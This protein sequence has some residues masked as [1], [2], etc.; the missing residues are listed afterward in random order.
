MRF[1]KP[2]LLA[3]ATLVVALCAWTGYWFYARGLALEVAAAWIAARQQEGWGIAHEPVQAGG[4]PFTV[5]LTFGAPSIAAPDNAWQW[6]GRELALEAQPWN[7]RRYRLESRGAQ[8]LDI[9]HRGDTVR[10]ALQPAEAAAVAT[11][12][13]NGQPK[14]LT[15][16]LRELQ[17]TGD[18]GKWQAAEIWL[19]ATRPEQPPASHMETAL[20]LS[21]AGADLTL[22]PETD[23]PLGRHIETLRG[24]FRLMG[25]IP[26]GPFEQ[27]VEA[28]RVDGGTVEVPWLRAVWNRVDLRAQGTMALDENWKPLASFSADI[29]GY[30]AGMDALADAALIEP[31]TATMAKVGLALLAKRPPEGGEP[32]LTVPITAQS[33]A[34][35]AG[36][37]RIATLSSFRGAVPPR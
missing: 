12:W 3:A 25:A 20:T 13:G 21:L 30:A 15:I 8:D 16:L 7:L 33:G 32:V 22:P 23:P 37:I 11:F 19:E 26:R 36:P 6:R 1:G 9:R 17:V 10:L 4:Y 14:A 5:R 34:L 29:R 27:A 18:A 28:W 35:Y 2:V 24:D 31:K